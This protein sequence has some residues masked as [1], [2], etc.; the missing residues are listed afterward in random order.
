MPEPDPANIARQLETAM[1][2]YNT[3]STRTKV[4]VSGKNNPKEKNSNFENEKEKNDQEYA[5][6]RRSMGMSSK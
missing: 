3:S 5:E 4:P 2:K 6:Y 1:Y